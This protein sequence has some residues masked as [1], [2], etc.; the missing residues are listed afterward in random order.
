MRD[1]AFAW[2]VKEAVSG[3]SFELGA[4]IALAARAVLTVVEVIYAGVVTLIGR[5]QG[6]AIAPGLEEVERRREPER[7]A[8]GDSGADFGSRLR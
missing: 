4:L 1:A 6:W 2:T 7:A 3:R 5:R 8:S